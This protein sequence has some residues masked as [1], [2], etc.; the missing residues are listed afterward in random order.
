MVLFLKNQ[1][2]LPVQQL[3]RM[4]GKNTNTK[5]AKQR[6]ELLNAFDTLSSHLTTTFTALSTALARSSS[7]ENKDASPVD[8]RAYVAI[9][10]GPSL[11]TAKSKVFLG[12]DQFD[13]RIWGMQEEQTGGNDD[14]DEDTDEDDESGSEAE[15]GDEEATSDEEGPSDSES[16]GSE[17]ESDGESDDEDGSDNDGGSSHTSETEEATSKEN[18]KI[19]AIEVP[20]GPRIVAPPTVSFAEEQR[21]LQN[22]ERLLSRTLAAAD[23]SGYGLASEMRTSHIPPGFLART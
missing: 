23:A 19:L 4:S 6:T 13:A 16:E 8:H 15:S 21:F 18:G 5:A 10:L 12:V 7:K 9:L 11:G 20:R 22:A 3:C 14:E 1:T 17:G 2:P